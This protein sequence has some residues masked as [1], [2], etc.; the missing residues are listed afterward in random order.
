MATIPDDLKEVV[1]DFLVESQESLDTI[2]QDLLYMEGHPEDDQKIGSIFRAIHSIKGACG[3]LGFTKLEKVSHSGE[4]VLSKIRDGHLNLTK[5]VMGALLKMVDAV[6]SILTQLEKNEDEGTEEFL[7]LVEILA[8][9]TASAKAKEVGSSGNGTSETKDWQSVKSDITSSNSP[10]QDKPI[11]EILVDS[12]RI[13]PMQLV[14]ALKEQLDGDPR[15]VGEILVE[16]GAVKPYQV[17]NALENQKNQAAKGPSLA[18]QNIRVDVGLL[19][20]LMNQMGELVLSR[21]QLLQIA[22][23]GDDSVLSAAAQKLNRIT[24][25]LQE[26]FMMTR[27]QPVSSQWGKF[28]RMI[29]DLAATCGKQ[30]RLEMEGQETELDKSLLEAIKDPLTHILRNSVDHGVETALERIAVGK[31]AEGCITLKA[32]QES[33]MVVIKI[34]DDGKGLNA[35]R[36]KAKALEKGLISATTIESMSDQAVVD[37]IFLPGF[38]TAEKVSNVSGRGVGMDVVRTNIE[39]V[40]GTVNMVSVYG[41]GTELTI[42]IPL[43]LAIIPALLVKVGQSI[44]AAPQSALV[45]VIRLGAVARKESMENLNGIYLYKYRSTLLPIFHLSKVVELPSL[46]EADPDATWFVLILQLDGKRFGLVVDRVLDTQEIVVKAL[47]KQ[48]KELMVYSGATILGNGQIAMIMDIAGLANKVELARTNDLSKT[49]AKD[50]NDQ[51]AKANTEQH[52]IFNTRD[53]SR[54]AVDLKSVLR[55]ER[56]EKPSM[57]RSGNWVVLQHR[58]NILP[59]VFLDM[60]EKKIAPTDMELENYT[61]GIEFILY[62][63]KNKV[64]GLVV[65]KI[66]DILEEVPSHRE[67]AGR[68]GVLWASVM[69]GHV[70]EYPDLERFIQIRDPAFFERESPK[71]QEMAV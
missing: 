67:S 11:G 19:D 26:G 54:F 23:A 61:E 41:K 47:S 68:D 58:E 14:D 48:L 39:K 9:I 13:E 22:S 29:R 7:P 70:T 62:Q 71:M 33:G 25:E 56:L 37:L 46:L 40:S 59:L 36:I 51:K 18:D 6:R 66:L 69:A 38:S 45:E 65:D 57:E 5:P 20:K 4:N 44:F 35:D 2:D 50:E 15:R 3:F 10:A 8:G 49:H 32:S 16:Q 27:M 64:V 30:V 60:W 43:T 28:P 31:Q 63:F 53:K 21:N 24:S 42:R 52:L 17:K 1:K 55:L 12:G 34:S